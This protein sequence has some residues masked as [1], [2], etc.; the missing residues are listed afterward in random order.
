MLSTS[1][2]QLNVAK[3]WLEGHLNTKEDAEKYLISL[4]AGTF[5]SLKIDG[6]DRINEALASLATKGGLNAQ[7]RE[8]MKKEGTENALHTG[9]FHLGKR[10]NLN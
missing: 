9:L 1:L 5:S 10:L 4:M 3:T 7:L 8:H 6:K 2:A